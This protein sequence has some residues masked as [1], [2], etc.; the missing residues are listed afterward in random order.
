IEDGGALNIWKREK[1]RRRDGQKHVGLDGIDEGRFAAT[2]KSM[3]VRNGWQLNAIARRTRDVDIGHAGRT[4]TE[5]KAPR[6]QTQG[7]HRHAGKRKRIGGKD[8]DAH[9]EVLY[10]GLMRRKARAMDAMSGKLAPK[11]VLQTSQVI[12]RIRPLD[13]SGR[14]PQSNLP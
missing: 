5:R 2:L 4:K 12:N 13:T 1:A 14:V 7:A 6:P 11:L 9:G 8:K 3:Q 10:E